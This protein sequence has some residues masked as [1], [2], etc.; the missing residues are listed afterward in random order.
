MKFQFD[1]TLWQLYTYAVHSIA[2]SLLIC[3]VILLTKILKK[4]INLK[5]NQE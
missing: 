3:C 5:I 2:L 1:A 4:Y